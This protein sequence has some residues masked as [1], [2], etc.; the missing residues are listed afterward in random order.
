MRST[1][2]WVNLY[3]LIIPVYKNEESIPALLTELEK[4][5]DH[6][7]QKL[8][9]TFV[10]DGSPDNSYGALKALLPQAKFRATL[11]QH[12]KNFGSFAAIR[13]GLQF[14]EGPL[15][16]VMAADLQ[17]PPALI[18]SFFAALESNQC[19]IAYGQRKARKDPFLTRL[20]STIFW[21]FYRAF[22]IKDIPDGGVDIFA[23]NLSARNEVLRFSES[24]SSLVAQLFWVGFRRKAIEYERLPRLQGKSAW[25]FSKKLNYLLDS[26]F[27]FTD[28]PIKALISI[29]FLGVFTSIMLATLVIAFKYFGKIPVS[30]YTALLI[31]IVFFGALNLLGI[32]IIGSYVH[33]AYEN[34]KMRPLSIVMA[35]EKF[36]IRQKKK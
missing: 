19:D 1:P 16:A 32:G 31:T 3:S 2:G 30:G 27:S 21:R 11:I 4:M 22:V 34:T 7:R 15:F 36:K 17:E 8:T 5:N 24:H 25:T 14:A 6:L 18:R 13:T 23:C 35:N 10:I 9:V 12:S 26:I 28:L 33:R 29:G 20:N